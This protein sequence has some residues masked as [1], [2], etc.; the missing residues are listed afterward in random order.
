[1]A[2]TLA[3]SFRAGLVALDIIKKGL[4]NRKAEKALIDLANGKKDIREI[5]NDNSEI[6]RFTLLIDSLNRA[7]TYAK[8]NVLKELYLAFDGDDKAEPND[9][10]FFEVLSIL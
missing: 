4:T 7:S 3:V 8:A 10:L 9:D 5:G 2:T 6:Y 1:M